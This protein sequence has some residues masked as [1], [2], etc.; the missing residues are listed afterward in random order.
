MNSCGPLMP[1][2]IG[3]P[4]GIYDEHNLLPIVR[5]GITATPPAADYEG[6]RQVLIDASVFPG[7]SGSPVFVWDPRGVASHETGGRIVGRSLYL[8]GV[9]SAVFFQEDTGR[10]EQVTI[11]TRQEPVAIFNRTID[12]GVVLKA[13]L[14]ME[15]VE[16]ALR[17]HQVAWLGEVSRPSFLSRDPPQ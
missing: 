14:I 9:L 1:S 12:I 5:R 3:Y 16:D 15:T 17:T 10:I 13:S 4:N 2:F 8:L 7:S 11:P 6:K